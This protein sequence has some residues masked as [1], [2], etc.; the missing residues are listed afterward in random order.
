M[1]P[2]HLEVLGLTVHAYGAGMVTAFFVCLMVTFRYKP[3]HLFSSQDIYNLCL[4]G[5]MA[6]LAAPR[7][8]ILITEGRFWWER[9]GFS[10]VP[11][12]I[13]AVILL[14][15]YCRLK[16]KPLL[17]VMDFF[18]PIAILGTAIH[19]VLGCYAAGCCYGTPTGLPWGMVFPEAC[20]AGI[21][22]PGEALH[23]TQLYY[24]LSALLIV[25]FLLRKQKSRH[26]PGEISAVG[27]I[28]L[29]CSYA[30]VTLFRGDIA[31]TESLLHLSS[32]QFLALG[33]ATAGSILLYFIK[34]TPPMMESLK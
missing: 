16:K 7:L 27:F 1:F 21:R 29:G 10:F 14:T 20:K 17:E 9:T 30:A 3:K 15:A 31:G 11:V 19:R 33:L 13:L 25:L 24:G 23:P 18:L 4:L 8:S 32:S 26:M 12:F 6:L 5:M 28:L 22:F 34:K 2:F